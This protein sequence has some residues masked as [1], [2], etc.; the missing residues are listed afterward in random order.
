MTE[1]QTEKTPVATVHLSA[2][3]YQQ[4]LLNENPPRRLNFFAWGSKAGKTTSMVLRMIRLVWETEGKRY[5]WI[6]PFH[7]QSKIAEDRIRRAFPAGFFKYRAS[8]RSI[9]GP[10]GTVLTFHS[11]DRPD[12]IPGEDVDGAVL[13]EAA[14]LKE[15]VYEATLSTTFATN[16]WIVAISTPTGRNWFYRE[17]RLGEERKANHFAKHYPTYINPIFQTEAGKQNLAESKASIPA[18]VYEQLVEAKFVADTATIFPDIEP[19]G[20]S[21]VPEPVP[22]E[23]K[24]Y[25]IAMDVG[26]V[27]D[28]N[29]S[30]VWDVFDAS[31]VDWVRYNG[32]D[33]PQIEYDTSQLSKRWNGAKVYVER[34]SPGLPIVQ[35]LAKAGVPC[36]LGPDGGLGF[37]TT[38]GSKSAIVHAWGLALRNQEPILPMRYPMPGQ[39]PRRCFPELYAEHENFEYTI[40]KRGNWSF[41]AGGGGHDDIVISC[42]IGWW[43]ISQ[44]TTVPKYWKPGTQPRAGRRDRT[45]V[46]Q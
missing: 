10:R 34:N 21:Y 9:T 29:V 16:G 11:G 15:E 17:F 27:V 4:E 32:V 41:G 19:C 42:M 35:S 26:Q 46:N 7:R 28:Y 44:N 8:E 1:A 18:A 12:T 43:A 14:R 23:G 38:A 40:N 24:V 39:D 6:A 5:R 13:D 33:Y 31:L 25:I 22:T 36:G 45:I 30:T 2:H 3:D 20:S 37:Q